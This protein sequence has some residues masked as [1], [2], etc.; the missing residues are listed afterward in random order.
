MEILETDR[1]ALLARLWNNIIVVDECWLWT[2]ERINGG[3]GRIYHRGKRYVAHQLAYLLFVGDYDRTLQLDHLCMVTRCIRPAHLE[4]VDGR[5][6]TLRG[7]SIGAVNA[8][9]THCRRGHEFTEENTRI[10]RG[11]R[12]C[13]ACGRE[14]RRK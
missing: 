10:Y 12:Y 8:R 2:G 11:R 1:V 6:N 14:R 7:G 9:L 3:Y 4:P 13:R 5:T